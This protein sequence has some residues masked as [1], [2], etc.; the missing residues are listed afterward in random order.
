MRQRFH[1]PLYTSWWY[2]YITEDKVF[3]GEAFYVARKNMQEFILDAKFVWKWLLGKSYVVRG[4]GDTSD[5]HVQEGRESEDLCIS[6][7]SSAANLGTIVLHEQ[8]WRQ[9]DVVS[10]IND[11]LI[12]IK[13][14]VARNVQRGERSLNWMSWRL[15]RETELMLCDIDN[16]CIGF[17]VHQA[18]CDTESLSGVSV[19][20]TCHPKVQLNHLYVSA[21]MCISE[22]KKKKSVILNRM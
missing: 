8:K 9:A 10:A 13:S 22:K 4:E 18:S 19:R 21:T 15:F 14:V 5:W 16:S 11:R 2:W 17:R 7:S 20:N 1:S 3:E 6:Y 12:R